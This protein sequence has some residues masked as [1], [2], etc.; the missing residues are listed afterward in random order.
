MWE[1]YRVGNT[2]RIRRHGTPAVTPEPPAQAVA[3]PAVVLDPSA[4][5][6]EIVAEAQARGIDSSGTK[7]E[8]LERLNG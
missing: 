3:Y 2:V 8:I 1:T 6:A 7:A 5:K 4:T